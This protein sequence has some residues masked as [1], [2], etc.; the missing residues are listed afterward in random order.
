M[1]LIDTSVWIDYLRGHDK[2]L[3]ARIRA[4]LD[5]GEIYL[6]VPVWIELLTGASPR[7][8]Q[9]LKRAFSVIPHLYPT[10]ST[11]ALMEKWTHQA[12]LVGERFGFADLLIGAI[13][14]ENGAQPWSRDGDFKR[15]EHLKF[16]KT[17]QE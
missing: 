1:I 7:A 14:A 13:A 12:G 5:R 11:W 17:Y 4:L 2:V 6:A 9:Q 3:V 16:F 8:H 10:T 15:M